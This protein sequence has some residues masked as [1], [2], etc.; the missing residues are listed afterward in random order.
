MGMYRELLRKEAKKAYKE[1]I[2]DMPKRNRMPFAAFY[3]QFKLVKSSNKDNEGPKV[4]EDFDVESVVN[5]N[6]IEEPN[7]A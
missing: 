4:E 7:K 3:K 5:V 2:K 6:K 1:H